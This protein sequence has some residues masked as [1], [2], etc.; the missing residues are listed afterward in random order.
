MA[1]SPIP[2]DPV[3]MTYIT[4]HN[5]PLGPAT[6]GRSTSPYRPATGLT[7]TDLQ[8]QGAKGVYSHFHRPFNDHSRYLA[9]ASETDR[10]AYRDAPRLAPPPWD[11]SPPGQDRSQ[12]PFTAPGSGR[13]YGSPGGYAGA[14]VGAAVDVGEATLLDNMTTRTGAPCYTSASLIEADLVT[15]TPVLEEVVAT[16]RGGPEDWR[17]ARVQTYSVPPSRTGYGDGG[18]R[19]FH[20]DYRHYKYYGFA[21]HGAKTSWAHNPKYNRTYA[22]MFTSS[23]DSTSP[24]SS[25]DSPPAQ[26]LQPYVGG[27]KRPLTR[28]EK[29]L[30]G[31]F[32][33]HSYAAEGVPADPH[34]AELLTDVAT[35]RPPSPETLRRLKVTGQARPRSAA[36]GA[37]AKSMTRA[38]VIE[39]F[40]AKVDIEARQ[41]LPPDTPMYGNNRAARVTTY[42]QMA[43]PYAGELNRSPNMG[44]QSPWHQRYGHYKYSG[45]A[46]KG[47]SSSWARNPKYAQMY[48]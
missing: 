20:Q 14:D 17:L 19:P 40:N 48:D 43:S 27:P 22:D 7:H 13:R 11:G 46:G 33:W 47:A 1:G 4:N 42:R 15:G 31:Q 6:P 25:V 41:P 26:P 8:L 44:S 29:A 32:S 35:G 3:Y 9:V 28:A 10:A 38:E 39:P 18:V 12:R 21:G 24:V 37:A 45:F 23:T 5:T 16:E 2:R 36:A 34:V 30:V